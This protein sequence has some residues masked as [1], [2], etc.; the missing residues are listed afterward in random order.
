MRVTIP[1]MVLL[2]GLF[3]GCVG[4]NDGAPDAAPGDESPPAVADPGE[5][6][7]ATGALSGIVTDTELV[8]LGGATLTL[9]E[10]SVET[11]SA[12]D[13]SFS[14]S[15]VPPGSY[16]LLAVKLGY[17]SSGQRVTVEA[18]R[19]A[20][21]VKVTL[22]PLPVVEPYSL[23]SFFT[24]YVVCSI[25]QG[26]VGYSEE[27]G[28]GLQTDYGTYG[29]N[30]NNKI[31]WKFNITTVEN[32]ETVYLEMDWKPA[33]AAA[34]KLAFHVAHGFVCTPSCGSKITY[35]SVGTNQGPPVL[36]CEIEGD[37]LRSQIKNPEKDL[38]WDITARV[39]ASTKP[40]T[41]GPTIVLDQA[42]QMYRTEFYG[43][44]MPDLYTAVADR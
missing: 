4:S 19:E 20:T 7:D 33:S 13:G 17:T 36:H 6:D 11:E 44:P 41:E 27:C 26:G 12:Q 9:Q 32:L 35:C 8:P 38:P 14:F 40:A 2:L 25:G 1:T 22:D 31:D 24:G 43:T 5:Y 42:V 18:G 39:W 15:R 10:A 23:V 16:A 3:S 37:T 34:S 21:G 29:K 30:P 28:E